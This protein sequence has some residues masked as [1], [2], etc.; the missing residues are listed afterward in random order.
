MKKIYKNKF[1]LVGL[2]CIH[3]LL[4]SDNDRL[5]DISA[6]QTMD[7]PS[8]QAAFE[9][10]EYGNTQFFGKVEMKVSS[11]FQVPIGSVIDWFRPKNS[12]FM[13][14]EGYQVCD[15]QKITDGPYK[16]EKTPNLIN[17][18]VMG[19]NIV[20]MEKTNNPTIKNGMMT[21]K[22]SGGHTH[23]LADSTGFVFPN[24]PANN[25]I[26]SGNYFVKDDNNDWKSKDVHIAVDKG[27]AS[28]SYKDEGQ[29][30]HSLGGKTDSNGIH[31][32]EFDLPP[33]FG[34]LKIMRIK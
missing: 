4:G 33:Y 13:I 2:V 15:G 25:Q 32:H 20:E 11:S 14:P 16:N 21:T 24:P 23:G 8:A 27:G 29:H 12:S 1:L 28:S 30:R 34:L 9:I 18:F 5:M 22:D 6:S 31:F 19:V 3:N 7:T 17:R 10:D 26:P